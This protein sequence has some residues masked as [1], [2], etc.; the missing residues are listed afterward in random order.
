MR[1]DHGVILAFLPPYSPDFNPIEE[2]FSVIKHWIKRNHELAIEYL[3][4][5]VFLE[6]AMRACS[7][8]QHARNHF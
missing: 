8:G 2:L 7:T 1:R 3:D 6:D 4:F 5:A